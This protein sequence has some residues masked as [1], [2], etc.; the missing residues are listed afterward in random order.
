MK[1][2]HSSK[3]GT[4]CTR[5]SCLHLS[6]PD[7]R[8]P[9]PHHQNPSDTRLSSHRKRHLISYFYVECGPSVTHR[10]P[11][12]SRVSASTPTT[13]SPHQL[14]LERRLADEWVG[15]YYTQ[16][17][18]SRVPDWK[19]GPETL[20]HLQN[21]WAWSRTPFLRGSCRG[22]AGL[23]LNDTQPIEQQ[24]IQYTRSR[25]YHP[26]LS[27]SLSTPRPRQSLLSPAGPLYLLYIPSFQKVS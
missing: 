21:S 8:A 5:C 7:R 25:H 13:P 14:A 9:P 2:H 22:E 20:A 17:P 26:S 23:R 27:R 6:A 10:Y 12:P 15:L 19:N 18:Q 1:T 4:N 3:A 16:T 24:H 11:Q